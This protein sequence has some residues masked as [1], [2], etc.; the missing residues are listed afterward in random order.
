MSKPDV[1]RWRCPT[2]GFDHKWKWESGEAIPG[3][4]TVYC[5]GGCDTGSKMN[6]HRIGP[7]HFAAIARK[8]AT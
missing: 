5:E 2:C 7:R 6:M 4:I 3:R 1:V 8:A